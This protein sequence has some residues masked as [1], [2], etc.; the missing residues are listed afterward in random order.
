M[1][2]LE[3]L[4]RRVHDIQYIA[5]KSAFSKSSSILVEIEMNF[6]PRDA[7]LARVFATATCPCVCPSHA[8]IVP[9]RAKAGS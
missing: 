3:L 7:M 1:G 8:G 5:L 2:V 9:S 6:Y 4:N